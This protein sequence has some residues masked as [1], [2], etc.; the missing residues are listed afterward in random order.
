MTSDPGPTAPNS[1]PTSLALARVHA[2]VLDWYAGHARPLPWRTAGTSP[3]GVFVSEVMA[4]QTPI[5]RVEPAWSAWLARWPR[6]ADLAAETPGEAVRAWGRLGYP[7]RALRL[8]AA[9]TEMVRRHAGEVPRTVESLRELPGVGAYTAAAVACFAHGI[10]VLVVDTNV[11]RVLARAVTGAALAAPTLTAAESALAE[12]A[13]PADPDDALVWNV[14]V[15][16]LGALVCT[17]RAP[18][19][20]ECPISSECRW[21]ARGCPPDPGPRRRGQAW[22]GTDRQAR[23]RLLQVLREADGPVRSTDLDRAWP[24]EVQRAR[25]LDGLVADGLIEPLSRGRYRLPAY[26][27]Y[28]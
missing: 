10:P 26:S 22:T 13:L 16:E 9:A 24:D 27:R 6:P 28:T 23:G 18:Q 7:R 25:C 20:A 17:A 15:M 21:V 4:Q 5:A 8:H 1:A 19:C 11:R 14:A 12:A 2:A 3:W